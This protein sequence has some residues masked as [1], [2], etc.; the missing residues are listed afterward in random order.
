MGNFKRIVCDHGAQVRSKAQVL[1]ALASAGVSTAFVFLVENE[2]RRVAM[3]A[4]VLFMP[5]CFVRRIT[6]EIYRSA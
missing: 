3:D 2:V 4:E 1:E 6:N 5:P